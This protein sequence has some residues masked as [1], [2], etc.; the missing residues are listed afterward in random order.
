[1]GSM[2][3]NSETQGTGSTV[4]L[5]LGLVAIATSFCN[6]G[7]IAFRGPHISEGMYPSNVFQ[8]PLVPWVPGIGFVTN[9]FMMA[10]I[11]WSSHMVFL[12]IVIAFLALYVLKK[13]HSKYQSKE[14][15]QE[16][17]KATIEYQQ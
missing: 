13:L 17:M 12:M 7:V 4:C 15:A 1:M 10:T 16:D 8:V 2:E 5:L 9:C 14:S 3:L 11:S 6:I